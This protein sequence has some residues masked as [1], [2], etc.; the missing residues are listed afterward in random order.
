MKS[1]KIYSM[2]IASAL[3][4]TSCGG[5]NNPVSKARKAMNEVSDVVDVAKTVSKSK[6]GLERSAERMEELK[7]VAPATKDEL[8]EW[9]PESIGDYKRKGFSVGN[10]GFA[11]IGSITGNYVDEDDS[12]RNFEISVIDGAG[13]AGGI[14]AMVYFAQFNREFEEENEDGFS[15]SMKKGDRKAVV[16]QNNRYKTAELEYMESERYYIKITGNEVDVDEL[17][18]VVSKLKTERLPG[19]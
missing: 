19:L 12:N 1:I 5:D 14:F 11:D 18:N 17:W 2:F 4:F 16:S 6:S 7:D 9:L 8:K 15:K 3:L 10:Q 13:E